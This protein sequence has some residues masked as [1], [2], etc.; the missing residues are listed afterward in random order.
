MLSLHNLSGAPLAGAPLHH[1]LILMTW[2]FLL[3]CPDSFAKDGELELTLENAEGHVLYSYP[4][5]NG[6]VFGIRYLHSVA[7]SPVTDYFLIKEGGIWLDRTVYEDFGAGLPH[8]PEGKQV[9]RTHKGKISISGYD[10][11]LGSFQ[12]RVGRVANHILL[13]MPGRPLDSQGPHWQ[14]LPLDKIAEP[15]SAIT[16]AVRRPAS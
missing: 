16:F 5:K 4:V 2:L 10:K 7:L 1:A 11:N 13:L 6:S 14:E 3:A 15:G 9:M 8:M 12:L